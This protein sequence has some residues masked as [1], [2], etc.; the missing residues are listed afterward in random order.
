[1]GKH[2]ITETIRLTADGDVLRLV[3]KVWYFLGTTSR[4]YFDDGLLDLEETLCIDGEGDEDEFRRTQQEKK[5]REKEIKR[6]WAVEVELGGKLI[7]TKLPRGV[8]PKRHITLRLPV[9]VFA[10]LIVEEA[11]TG[12]TR[13]QIVERLLTKGL[14]MNIWNQEDQDRMVAAAAKKGIKDGEFY[15]TD[16]DAKTTHKLDFEDSELVKIEQVDYTQN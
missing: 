11:R 8:S 12:E 15:Y 7:M 14:A 10:A 3:D 1:M 13:T 16:E 2:K 5:D 6:L 9:P 4:I